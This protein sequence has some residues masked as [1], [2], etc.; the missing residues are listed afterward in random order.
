[1][2][3]SKIASFFK[4]HCMIRLNLYA[5]ECGH[6]EGNRQGRWA[7]F[8]ALRTYAHLSYQNI[9]PLVE[10]ISCYR[11]PFHSVDQGQF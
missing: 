8:P 6:R 10:G 11:I 3:G 2:G 5:Q 1:M 4:E 7:I 9:A